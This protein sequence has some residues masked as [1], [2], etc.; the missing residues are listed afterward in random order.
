MQPFISGND[1]YETEYQVN[2]FQDGVGKDLHEKL[3]LR[4]NKSRNWV[5]NFM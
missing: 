4:A 1:Y 5:Q 2:L 3:I